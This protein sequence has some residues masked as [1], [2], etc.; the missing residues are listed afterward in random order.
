M[1]C[2]CGLLHPCLLTKFNNVVFEKNTVL[3]DLHVFN[4]LWVKS[5]YYYPKKTVIH[6]HVVNNNNNNNLCHLFTEVEANND[7]YF[8]N[9]V[10]IHLFHHHEMNNIL[11]VCC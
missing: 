3:N 10:N 7:R 4:M 1:S 9:I 5:Y 8:L 6:V 2:R 11:F